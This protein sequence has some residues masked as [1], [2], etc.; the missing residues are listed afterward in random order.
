MTFKEL[1]AS[2]KKKFLEH[3]EIVIDRERL[4]VNIT[5]IFGNS[6]YILWDNNKIS[7]E[8]F[9]Y[10]D[11]DVHII[12]SQHDL[13]LLFT[14]RQYL[15]ATNQE[16][17]IRGSF[18][19]VMAFQRILSYITKDNFY[20]VQEEMILNLLRNQSAVKQDLEII[21]QALHLLLSNNLIGM[22]EKISIG[23][24]SRADSRLGFSD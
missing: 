11:N 24:E 21:M 23:K 22:T 14:E 2:V 5:D 17:N 8:P 1:F 9:E 19:D 4:S 3:P 12:A 6:F 18:D 16:L 20:V 15:F 13:I 10:R 7:V